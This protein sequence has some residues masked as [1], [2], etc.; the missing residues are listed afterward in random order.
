MTVQQLLNLS[1]LT[2]SHDNPCIKNSEKN[3]AS[4]LLTSINIIRVTTARKRGCGKVMFVILF[5][6]GCIPPWSHSPQHT[7]PGHTHTPGLP[8]PRT[9]TSYYGKQVGG[10]HSTDSTGMLSCSFFFVCSDFLKSRAS[11]AFS[12]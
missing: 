5:T 4:P 1:T 12:K 9:H 8:P 7:H 2:F 10:T 3:Y 11:T 6:E